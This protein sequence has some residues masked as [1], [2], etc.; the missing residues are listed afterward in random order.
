[1]G[2]YA[3]ET[4][5]PKMKKRVFNISNSG[6]SA[7][8]SHIETF[9]SVSVAITVVDVLLL[10]FYVYLVLKT[11]LQAIIGDFI[12][13]ENENIATEMGSFATENSCSLPE[14]LPKSL[15]LGK[16]RECTVLVHPQHTGFYVCYR[17]L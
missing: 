11:L 15:S 7:I 3:T 14:L 13:T 1:M 5:L 16:K 6:M 8:F 2:W 10:L 12:A 17:I 4:S 9:F